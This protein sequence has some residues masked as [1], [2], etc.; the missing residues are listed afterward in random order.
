MSRSKPILIEEKYFDSVKKAARSLHI[1]KTTLI[2]R[3]ISNNWP[4]YSFTE[5][6]LPEFKIC[7]DCKENKPLVEFYK[8]CRS[9]DGKASICKKC[10]VISGVKRQK[11][12][13]DKY[14]NYLLNRNY[15]ISLNDYN[16]IF[17]EQEGCCAICGKHQSEFELALSVDHD[18]ATNKIRGLLCPNCNKG[19]GCF[20]DNVKLLSEAIN[21]LK[22][23]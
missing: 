18:H 17:A 14:K 21:F 19:L 15:G 4:K 12:D 23:N 11:K 20:K 5:R 9:A 7:C 2:D 1:A 22:N 6:R 16:K 3:C 10:S 8:F 13:P